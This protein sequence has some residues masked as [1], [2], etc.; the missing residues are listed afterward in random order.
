MTTT[1]SIILF[2]NEF[3]ATL[4]DGCRIQKSELR[5]LADALIHA[6]VHINGVQFEWNGSSGQRMITAGQQVAFRAEMRRL[7]R[8]QVKGLAVAA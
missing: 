5:E 3:V 8:R 6:G 2:K 4:S 7:E 1:A